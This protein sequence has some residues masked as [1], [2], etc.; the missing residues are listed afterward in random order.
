MNGIKLHS[1]FLYE[2]ILLLLSEKLGNTVSP[3]LFKSRVALMSSQHLVLMMGLEHWVKFLPAHPK[4]SKW[5]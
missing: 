1:S 2:N 5:D 4:D 3:S